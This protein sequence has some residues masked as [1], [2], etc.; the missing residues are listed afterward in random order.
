M[1]E[2]LTVGGTDVHTYATWFELDFT[3]YAV[4]TTTGFTDRGLT[5]NRTVGTASVVLDEGANAMSFN[6]N[7]ALTAGL[8]PDKL[9]DNDWKITMVGKIKT[10]ATNPMIFIGRSLQGNG[11]GTWIASLTNT[12]NLD[13]WYNSSRAT[14]NVPASRGVYHT[15][16]FE[17]ISNKLTATID[18]VAAINNVTIPNVANGTSFNLTVGGS[19]DNPLY[20]SNMF[21]RSMKVETKKR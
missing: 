1:L 21:M 9:L 6:G 11:A 18:G 8:T 19:W 14:G 7:G 3:K 2:L 5:F 20:H 15:F 17:S 13:W 12:A 4:G 10:G 16:I